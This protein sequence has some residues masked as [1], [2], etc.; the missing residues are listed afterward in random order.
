V[1]YGNPETTTG[2]KALKFY[3]SVRID[4]RKSEA[5]K[6]GKE[7]IGNRTK[8]KIV[9]NKV[10]PPFRSC[11]VDMLY[12]E[13]ISREGELLDI[14]V[15][16]DLVQKAGSFYSYNGERIGQGRDN[17]RRY[18]RDHPDAYDAVEA[19]IRESFK[20]GGIEAPMEAP[21][22]SDDDEELEDEEFELDE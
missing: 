2:G 5:I 11:V 1:M 21:M 17:A 13:G 15:E 8:I 16:Q 10:A 4:I 19:K 3:A 18:F 9:K 12:G 22:V 6:E 20:T 14:A 7:I